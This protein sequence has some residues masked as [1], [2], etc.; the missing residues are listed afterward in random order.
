MLEKYKERRRISKKTEV[1]HPCL[2]IFK[3][4]VVG[5]VPCKT[6]ML[7]EINILIAYMP[8]ERY[9]Q[10]ASISHGGTRVYINKGAAGGKSI[11]I[12]S[13]T[14]LATPIFYKLKNG[15]TI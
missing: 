4:Q 3:D 10:F 15:K 13:V 2:A 1:L 11:S 8:V 5:V 12:N 7:C 6:M 9:V 14:H